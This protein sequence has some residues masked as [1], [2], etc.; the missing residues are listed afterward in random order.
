M[1]TW[2]WTFGNGETSSEF[3]PMITYS[4]GSYVAQLVV[5]NPIGCTDTA[6]VVIIAE[7][8]F[9][10]TFPEVF[11]P[12][13]DAINDLFD[14]E[15]LGYDNF[16]GIIR[17]RWGK[18]V[19]KWSSNDDVW[20]GKRKNNGA[21]CDEGVYFWTISGTKIDGVSNFYQSGTITLLRGK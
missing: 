10:I 1:Q 14:V 6:R 18:V 2:Q 13:G 5:S 12:N 19:H 16:E 9:Q 3:E 8:L 17:D 4:Y 7:A 20:N 15:I 11:S 21:D